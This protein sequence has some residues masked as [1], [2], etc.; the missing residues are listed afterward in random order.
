MSDY[1]CVSTLAT[2]PSLGIASSSVLRGSVVSAST[3]D[4]NSWESTFHEFPIFHFRD[5]CMK[6]LDVADLGAN[7]TLQPSHNLER[8]LFNKVYFSIS[9]MEP[10]V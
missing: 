6:L 10:Y 2:S 5:H 3:I 1:P 7:F 9:R 4:D 8:A